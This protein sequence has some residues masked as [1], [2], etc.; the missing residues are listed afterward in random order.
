MQ[1]SLNFFKINSIEWPT[2]DLMNTYLI[3]MEVI[4]FFNI[5]IE[6]YKFC[7][8]ITREAYSFIKVSVRTKMI[9]NEFM[10]EFVLFHVIICGD[11]LFFDYFC[12]NYGTFFFL[13]YVILD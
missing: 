3:H 13:I 11:F 5:I 9:F 8:S 12:L 1:H 7:Q 10:A 2:E 4:K 6:D